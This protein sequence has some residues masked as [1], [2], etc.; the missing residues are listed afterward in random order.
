VTIQRLIVLALADLVALSACAERPPEKTYQT[1]TVR[2]EDLTKYI[3]ANGSIEPENAVQVSAPVEGRIEK[4][5]VKEGDYVRKGQVL[6][7]MSSSTRTT[8]MDMAGDREKKEKEYWETQV[9]PTSV[10]SPVSGRVVTIYLWPGETTT[11]S[12]LWI[13]TGML[14]RADVDE[15]DLPNVRVGQP[16]GIVF[17]VSNAQLLS[18]KVSKIARTS[19]LVNNVNVYGIEVTWDDADL[20]KLPFEVRFG[21]SVTLFLEQSTKKGALAIPANAVN[22]RSN[23]T[24]KVLDEALKPLTLKLGDMYG[25]QVE[26]LSGAVAG[27]KIKVPPF[28]NPAQKVRETPLLFKKK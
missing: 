4:M 1:V 27:Q 19:K 12:I 21:M 2:Q 24:V 25:E 13:A 20:K 5:L 18:G 22:G 17:D 9:R 10:F 3:E 28:K 14:I 11:R 6:A 15:T 8:L 26:V 23:A 7:V 16:V